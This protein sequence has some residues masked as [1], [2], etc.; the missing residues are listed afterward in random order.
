[1]GSALIVLLIALAV[2]AFFLLLIS[3]EHRNFKPFVVSFFAFVALLIWVGVSREYA[4]V[5]Y[6]EYHELHNVDIGN[7]VLQQAYYIDEDPTWVNHDIDRHYPVD[8][9]HIKVDHYN[10]WS[11]GI[12]WGDME[13]TSIVRKD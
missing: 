8:K 10:G 4:T 3:A 13:E 1:M 5:K 7:G 2:V 6:S 11:F 9:Y 12:H